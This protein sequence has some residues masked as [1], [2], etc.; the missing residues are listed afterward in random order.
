MEHTEEA[1]NLYSQI[2]N[3]NL[4]SLCQPLIKQGWYLDFD[5]KLKCVSRVATDMPWIFAKQDDSRRCNLWHGIF[6]NVFG[7]LPSPCLECWKVVVRPK[8]VR[9]LFELHEIQKEFELSSKAGIEVRPS[10]PGLYGGYFYCDS[11][12]H[13][14]KVFESVKEEIYRRLDNASVILKRGCTEFEHKFGDSS[15]WENHISEQQIFLEKK[16]SCFI[17]TSERIEQPQVVKEAIYKKW[18]EWAHQSGDNT[19][20]LFTANT[21]LYPPYRTYHEEMLHDKESKYNEGDFGVEHQGPSIEV[22]DQ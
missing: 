3:L 16:L 11:K 8:T 12:D 17:E 9:D 7:W 21:P 2:A 6:F 10:V 19:Y 1:I 20:L 15:E 4:V 5:G 13:G 22:I 18:I 14:L